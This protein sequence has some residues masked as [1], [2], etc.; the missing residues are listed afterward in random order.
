MYYTNGMPASSEARFWCFR[1]QSGWLT[2][3]AI[4]LRIVFDQNVPVG[5]RRK[6]ALVVLGSNIWPGVREHAA[7]WRSDSGQSRCGKL[8]CNLPP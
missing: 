7:A 1:R 8:P 6:L 2:P 4:A 3:R 5:V